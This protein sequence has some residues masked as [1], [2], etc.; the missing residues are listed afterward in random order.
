[1]VPQFPQAE[2]YAE[3]TVVTTFLSGLSSWLWP[4]VLSPAWRYARM[5]GF[6]C[7]PHGPDQLQ[8]FTRT[9]SESDIAAHPLAETLVQGLDGGIMSDGRLGRVEGTCRTRSFTLRDMCFN[10]PG[11]GCP[12][13]ITD[14]LGRRGGSRRHLAV[15]SGDADAG[16][17]LEVIGVARRW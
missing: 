8:Q 10:R 15:G 4:A 17:G 7:F 14:E 9:V 3:S 16:N 11:L 1:M 12:C 6:A 13:R 2:F 5:V